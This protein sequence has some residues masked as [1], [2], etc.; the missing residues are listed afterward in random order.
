MP[1]E[2]CPVLGS[3]LA[4]VL[5]AGAAALLVTAAV[6]HP[7]LRRR[8][9]S[10]RSFAAWFGV[11]Y[12]VVAIG[13][14]AV[15]RAVAFPQSFQGYGNAFVFWLA[16]A[17]VVSV[18]LAS[19]TAYAYD[20]FR[21]VTALLSLFVATALTW[22]VFLQVGG[23]TDALWIWAILFMPVFIAGAAV[24]L[25]LEWLLRRLLGRQQNSGGA[26]A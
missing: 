15:V 20:R 11:A 9:S 2:P 5:V 8:A 4:T 16:L 14:W 7:V 18:V 26:V 25:V 10:R 24:L 22:F 13:L 6:W 12:A 1:G 19:G 23:E 3:T 21:Y 17:V